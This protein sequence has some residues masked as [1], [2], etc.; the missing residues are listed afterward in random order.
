MPENPE[1]MEYPWESAEYVEQ[2]RRRVEATS[3]EWDDGPLYLYLPTRAISRH[4]IDI[5]LEGTSLAEFLRANAWF[6][7][8]SCATAALAAAL[9]VLLSIGARSPLGPIGLMS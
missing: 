3:Q 2:L 1:R 5:Q 6:V 9:A 7:I 8:A 4:F